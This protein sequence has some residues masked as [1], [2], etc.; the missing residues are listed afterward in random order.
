MSLLHHNASTT[1]KN[2]EG[3][4]ASQVSRDVRIKDVLEGIVYYNV[5]VDVTFK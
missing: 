2:D 3:R 5:E 1:I 4:K